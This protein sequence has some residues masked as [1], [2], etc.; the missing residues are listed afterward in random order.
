MKVLGRRRRWSF[1]HGVM[2][3]FV[4]LTFSPWCPRALG[5]EPEEK[6]EEKAA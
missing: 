3:L 4:K 5:L 2:Q 6:A 1:P